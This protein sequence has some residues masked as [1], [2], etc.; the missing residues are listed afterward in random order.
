MLPLKSKPRMKLTT[1]PCVPLRALVRLVS[2][3]N[4]FICAAVGMMSAQ[5]SLLRKTNPQRWKR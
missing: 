1:T 5:T 3:F 4:V 2:W